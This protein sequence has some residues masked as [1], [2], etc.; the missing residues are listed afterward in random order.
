MPLPKPTENE[1]QRE[2]INR[3]VNDAIV[4]REFPSSDQRVAIC[5]SL[6]DDSKLKRR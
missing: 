2:Y 5:H 1:V 3:C 6:W 4:K